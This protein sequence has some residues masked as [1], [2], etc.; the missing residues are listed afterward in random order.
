[1]SGA[2]STS[3]GFSL[4]EL[5][6]ATACLTLIAAAVFALLAGAGATSRREWNALAARRVASAAVAAVSRDLD[7]AGAG[8]EDADAVMLG[9]E[10][11]AY[12]SSSAGVVRLVLAAG[13]AVEVLRAEPGSRYAVDGG[14]TL[15]V[16]DTVAALASPDRPPAAPLPLGTIV[17]QAPLG[18]DAEVQVAW[19]AAEAAAVSAWGP[20]RALLPVLLREYDT[21]PVD[22]GLQLGRRNLGGSRQPVVDGL[23]AF[24]VEWLV[25]SDADGHADARREEVSPGIGLRLCA[26]RVAASATP[27]R[28]RLPGARPAEIMPEVATRWVTLGGC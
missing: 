17:G 8:L 23:D 19:Q 13:T 16:G 18:A 24:A 14:A 7:R 10:R 11:I 5:L 28:A 15:G 6:V 20:P 22:G 26:A 1:M 12:A 27:L 25:D 3:A 2:R 4:L 21:L 9:G